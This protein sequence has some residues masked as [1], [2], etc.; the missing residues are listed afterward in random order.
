MKETDFLRLFVDVTQQFCVTFSQQ[1]P[2]LFRS[3]GS[4]PP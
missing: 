3:E 4:F 1:L 2:E